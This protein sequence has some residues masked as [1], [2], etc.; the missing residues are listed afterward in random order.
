MQKKNSNVLLRVLQGLEVREYDSYLKDFQHA[1]IRTEQLSALLN[2]GQAIVLVSG[3]VGV[4]LTALHTS[5]LTPGD[6]VMIQGLV[7]Q[8]WTPLQFLGWFYR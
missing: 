2:A 8:L 7:M 3:M 6:L 5:Q 4:L 1:S